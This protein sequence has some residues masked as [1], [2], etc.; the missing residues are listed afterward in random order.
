[1]DS[2][3]PQASSEGDVEDPLLDKR[4]RI[5]RL[6]GEGGMGEVFLA[7]HV[8]LRKQ[9][10]VKLLRAEFANREDVVKR[11][12]REAQAAASVGH[13]NIIEVFDVGVSAHNEP[14]LV[15]EY[16]EGESLRDLL[17]R[18]GPMNLAA[19]CAVIEPTLLALQA[20][21]CKG[22]IHRDLKP[23]NIFLVH[24]SHEPPVVKLID[25]GISKIV[26]GEPDQWRTQTGFVMGTPAYMSP[27]QARG[28]SN[29]DG[30]TDLFSIGTIL[31]EMLTGGLPFAG[32]NFNEFFANLLTA[33]P[34]EPQSVFDKFP[35]EAAS[36]LRKAIQKDPSQR[37]QTATEMLDALKTLTEYERRDECLRLLSITLGERRFAAGDLG[38]PLPNVGGPGEA[39]PPTSEVLPEQNIG[40][41]PSQP[42][43]NPRSRRTMAVLLVGVLAVV[44]LALVGAWWPGRKGPPAPIPPVD[45][46]KL[47]VPA[48]P[49]VPEIPIPPPT[50]EIAKP[51]PVAAPPSSEPSMT[52]PQDKPEKPKRDRRGARPVD[53]SR[54]RGAASPVRIHEEFE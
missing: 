34:R 4:Y 43:A 54:Y 2:G 7:E 29:L 51:T 11:F 32:S 44:L 22:I 40:A 12:Y 53:H 5:I 50:Q 9:V 31:F 38:A 13:K 18:T 35:M 41:Q 42:A 52:A 28:A 19:A 37:F 33:E 8:V 39:K 26:S 1:M 49:S 25:F 16:L 21:H 36:L 17:R 27:E 20:A 15:M 6:L 10:A 48:H 3:N 24:G 30:R 46:E 47:A 45:Q 14:Y 23:E